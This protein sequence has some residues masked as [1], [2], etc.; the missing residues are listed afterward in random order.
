ME[1]RPYWVEY[2]E[3]FMA[4][5]LVIIDAGCVVTTD[6]LFHVKFHGTF[7]CSLEMSRCS[8]ARQ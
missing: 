8:K 2:H 6:E 7:E 1:T 3:V 5:G 4:C